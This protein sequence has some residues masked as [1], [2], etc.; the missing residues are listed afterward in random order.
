MS[1]SYVTTDG[2]SASLSWYKAPIRGLRPDFFSVRNMEYVWQ[3]R[4]WFHGEPCLMRG[5][6]CLLYVPLAF[7]S[8]VFLDPSPLGLV[9]V[10]YCLRLETSLFVASYDS[11]GHGGGIRPRLHTGYEL[12]FITRGEPKRDHHLE[13]FRL[14]LCFIRCYETYVNLVVTLWFL[15][16]CSLLWS[17]LV[18]SRCL[19]M[20]YSVTIW[21]IL[22][23]LQHRSYSQEEFRSRI[24]LGNAC[25]H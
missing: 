13:N 16:A 18:A 22:N 15:Q 8:A 10:F 11:Q 2:Q 21:I 12:S 9:T 1:E 24:N 19:A 4:F 17:T 20:D 3:L 5:R 25:Y 7:A 23:I 6:V 14:L